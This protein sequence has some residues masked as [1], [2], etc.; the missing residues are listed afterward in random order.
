MR[1]S[2]SESNQS[3]GGST[4]KNKFSRYWYS[5][6]IWSSQYAELGSN[7]GVVLRFGRHGLHARGDVVEARLA[8]EPRCD[9]DMNPVRHPA[10][11]EA[12]RRRHRHVGADKVARLVLCQHAD[13]RWWRR[14]RSRRPRPT[15]LTSKAAAAAAGLGLISTPS[16][17]HGVFVGGVREMCLRRVVCGGETTTHPALYS[18][19]GGE[20][21]RTP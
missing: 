15:A 12:A 9:R 6:S 5:T 4:A 7:W 3:D 2:S 1:A 8:D 19:R 10:L 13:G 11:R 20:R 16:R 17:I 21:M 14:R 18:V